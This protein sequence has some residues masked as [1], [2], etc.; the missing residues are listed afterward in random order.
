[1]KHDLMSQSDQ[2]PLSFPKSRQEGAGGIC[3]SK[4]RGQKIAKLV[5]HFEAGQ[6]GRGLKGYQV[7]TRDGSIKQTIPK[8]NLFLT[9]IAKQTSPKCTKPIRTQIGVQK[10]VPTNR[11]GENQLDIMIGSAKQ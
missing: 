5:Q 11:E 10:L 2:K 4:P 3:K 9:D 1:M 7:L 6:S 8:I